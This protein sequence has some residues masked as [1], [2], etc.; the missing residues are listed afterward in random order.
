MILIADSGSTKTDWIALDKKGK[1]LFQTQTLG[2]NP[3]VLTREIIKERIINNFELYQHRAEITDV[4]FYGAGLGVERPKERINDVFGAFFQNAKLHIK[5]DTYAALYAIT[6]ESEPCI[7]N[8]LGTGS[9]CSFYDG[10]V[11]HQKVISLGYILMDDASGN[12]FGR[13]LIRDFHFHKMPVQLSKKFAEQFE[14][15]AEAIKTHLYR[16]PNPNT[17]LAT[18]ARFL[19][20][21]KKEAYSQELINKGLNLFLDNQITQYAE[22]YEVPIH[23]VGSIAFYLQ[24]EIAEILAA[25]N[26]QLGNILKAPIE[27]LVQYHIRNK[28]H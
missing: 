18:F 23:F 13:Q 9:N 12:Y 6:K 11:I 16:E 27:G 7:V 24:E 22:C 1:V 15:S 28:L 19:I 3:Q 4:Y 25:N 14:L 20:E 17:Y 26:L 2:L 10:K 8:I 21:N 5:E